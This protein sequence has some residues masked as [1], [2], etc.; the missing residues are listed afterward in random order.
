M[1]FVY[2]TSTGVRHKAFI[3]QLSVLFPPTLIVQEPKKP[4]GTVD[5]VPLRAYA[6]GLG[7]TER[8]FFSDASDWKPNSDVLETRPGG[9]NDQEVLKAIQSAKPDWLLVFGTSILGH[10]VLNLPK[11]HA[12]NI[13]TGLTQSFR[14]VDSAFWALHD[15]LPQ[16]IGTTVHVID[17]KIDTG[18]VLLQGRPNLATEDSLQTIFLKTVA[19][20]F[21]L[22][23]DSLNGLIEG[24]LAPQPLPQ[25]GKLYQSK[26]FTETALE[27]VL[28][29]K[30][31]ILETYLQNK[32][33]LDL[34]IPL[35]N[36]L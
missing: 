12:L 20:G 21:D 11:Y 18:D 31:R 36:A 30:T 10:E 5:S 13:H 2:L 28:A 4:V 34:Q 35:I 26:H 32:P 25:K 9:I 7:E 19:L 23:Q 22:V 1:N 29:K 33:A 17:T 14:G 15:E 24:S 27:A 3:Q 16:A 6:Q 8:T